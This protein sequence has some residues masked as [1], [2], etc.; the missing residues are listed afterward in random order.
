MSKVKSY[1]FIAAGLFLLA[2]GVVLL[3][4]VKEPNHFLT[5]LP[6]V[7]I[8]IGCGVFGNGLAQFFTVRMVKKYPGMQKQMEI[9]EKDERNKMLSNQSKE[10]RMILWCMPLV[11]CCL[12]SSF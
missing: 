9:E 6:Y 4:T 1:S 11:H 5:V 2:V 12:Y 8:G 10:R 3:I 7:C